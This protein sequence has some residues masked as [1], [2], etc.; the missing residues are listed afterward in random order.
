LKFPKLGDS[1]SV[2][3]LEGT[4]IIRRREKLSKINR[5]ILLNPYDL[6]DQRKINTTS[7]YGSMLR[8][9]M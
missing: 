2:H 7:G 1:F 9:L 4:Y 8:S 3:I 6:H 5:I